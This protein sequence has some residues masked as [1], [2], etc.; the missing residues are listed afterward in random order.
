VK[1]TPLADTVPTQ[2]SPEVVILCGGRGTR[3]APDTDIIPKPLV[4][5]AGKPILWH[6]MRHYASYGFKRFVLCLG[7]R[8]EMIRDY[9]LNY[10]LHNQDITLY[11]AE[12]DRR[13]VSHGSEDLDWEITFADTGNNAQTGARIARVARYVKSP[14]FLCTY[15]DG[16]S[17]IDLD[18]L[19]NFHL[20]HGRIAT[21][22]GVHPPA[23]YGEMVIGD[24][25]RVAEFR[26]KP[27]LTLHPRGGT[28]YVNGGFFVFDRQ[29]FRYLSID[30]GCILERE[31]IERLAAEGELCIYQ[32]HGFWQCMDTPKDRDMLNQILIERD[33]TAVPTPLPSVRERADVQPTALGAV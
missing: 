15:G 18:A 23:R 7:Y 25:I 28:G 12:R 26:E 9:F 8:G 4:Q 17:D 33:Q 31:P 27:T 10:Q 16:V 21:V 2:D 24:G 6:I 14:Y 5:V 3:L 20:E 32:H 13:V 29:F 22:S 19:L 1:E 30:D 11:M